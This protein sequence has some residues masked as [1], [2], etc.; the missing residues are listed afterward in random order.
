LLLLQYN[1][2]FPQITVKLFVSL[3]CVCAILPGKAIP[4]M[5][6]IVSGGTLNP[7]H[8]LTQIAAVRFGVVSSKNNGRLQMIQ[9]WYKS[10]MV[11]KVLSYLCTRAYVCVC[12]CVQYARVVNWL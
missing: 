6:Y 11:W 10:S 7:I 5:T 3:L 8:S 9:L 1:Y 12:V 4:E 2:S